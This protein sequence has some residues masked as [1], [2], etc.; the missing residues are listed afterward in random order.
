MIPGGYNA[1]EEPDGS[2]KYMTAI[3]RNEKIQEAIA[4]LMEKRDGLILG[5]GS[6]FQA[7]IKLGL[8]PYGK[9]LAP[10]AER[11]SLTWNTIGRHM[12]RLVNVRI[13]S[14][15]SP[16]FSFA[17]PGDI[18]T[19]PVSHGE[20][21]FIA[22]EEQIA[23][24]IK[25][26]QIAAQYT[27]F[28]GSASMGLDFNPNGSVCAIEAITSTDGRILGKMGHSERA[29]E[30]LY[31]NVPGNYGCKIFESGVKYFNY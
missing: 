2:G 31:K 10:D 22:G 8:V 18:F 5:I 3:L 6:G 12:S 15:K 19:A 20:G 9:I 28:Y 16:W 25:N 23:M 21:R 7:L 1:P 13:A 11:P 24:L 4:D 27:D 26:G 14:V 30:F 29:G 17:S